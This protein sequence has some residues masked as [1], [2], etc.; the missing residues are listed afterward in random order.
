MEVVKKDFPEAKLC[1][2]NDNP[3]IIVYS[4]PGMLFPGK[5]EIR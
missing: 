3:T 1:E 4:N 5:I 2:K